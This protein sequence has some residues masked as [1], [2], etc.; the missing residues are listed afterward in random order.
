LGRHAVRPHIASVLVQDHG[1]DLSA[2][3]AFEVELRIDHL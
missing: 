1:N 2:D 3:V